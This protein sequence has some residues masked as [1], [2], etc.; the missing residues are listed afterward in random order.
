MSKLTRPIPAA[1]VNAVLEPSELT[2]PS[3][4]TAETETEYRLGL[5]IGK[6]HVDAVLLDPDDTL[7]AKLKIPAVADATDGAGDAIVRIL[8]QSGI[9]AAQ[10]TRIMIGTNRP[11]MSL[12]AGRGLEPVAVIRV[13]DPSSR[14]V[15]P[16]FGWPTTLR[17]AV[18]IG[19]CIVDGGSEID[20]R[21]A[22]PLDESALVAFL[23]ALRTPA[24]VAVTAVLSA[25]D[26]GPEIAVK[27]I[28]RRELGPD[29]SV[30]MSHEIGSRGLLARE[31]ATVLNAALVGTMRRFADELTA[32][33]HANNLGRASVYVTRN[34]GS[35][36]S[37]ALAQHFPVLTINSGPANALHGAARLS[38][39]NDA[40]VLDVG[41]T[42]TNIGMLV[43]GEPQGSALGAQLAGIQMNFRMPDIATVRIGGRTPVRADPDAPNGVRLG[44][45]PPGDLGDV[46]SGSQGLPAIPVTVRPTATLAEAVAAR[47]D[48]AAPAALRDATRQAVRSILT[49]HAG[50]V[51]NERGVLPLIAVGG[52]Q[53]L[54]PERLLNASHIIRPLHGDVASAI[55]AATAS[56]GGEVETIVNLLVISRARAIEDAS[57]RAC[58]HAVRA[59][60]DPR[61]VAVV[62]I[63]ETPLTY[64]GDSL[65]RFRVRASGPARTGA[66]R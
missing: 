4:S 49:L 25:A 61:A 40:L 12:L 29:V 46:S 34:D 19:E 51:R 3:N 13:G 48:D 8:Q 36:M 31:N 66:A 39:V 47:G 11:M 15:R 56:V 53:A 35:L 42:T 14:A 38:G 17:A 55:G 21:P 58:R 18:S 65:V 37:L 45:D 24:G 6:T 27:N 28:V 60:A 54:V 10:V 41:G 62:A 33:L 22:A 1:T 9:R 5:D 2:H 16:L 50:R 23:R 64:V 7:V 52:A 20:G 26:P 32:V 59:G 30:S 63:E 57:A 44:D 43:G